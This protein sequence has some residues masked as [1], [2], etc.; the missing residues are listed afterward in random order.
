MGLLSFPFDEGLLADLACPIS[1]HELKFDKEHNVLVS[2]AVGVAF[3]NK[4][5]GHAA[6]P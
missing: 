3:S 6:F 5:G 4:Q 1:G 2:E